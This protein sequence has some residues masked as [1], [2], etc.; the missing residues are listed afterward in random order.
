VPL[1]V[2]Q[3]VVPAAAYRAA[4]GRYLFPSPEKAVR[5]PY[6]PQEPLHAPRQG[7]RVLPQ[8]PLSVRVYFLTLL[9]KIIDPSERGFKWLP[10]LHH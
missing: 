7:L 8:L 1:E 9:L 5:H 3:A 6:H 2:Q 10:T 4:A